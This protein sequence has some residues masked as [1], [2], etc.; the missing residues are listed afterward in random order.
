MGVTAPTV[1][2]MV[3]SLEAIGLVRTKR[4]PH[5]R[6]QRVVELTKE[7]LA[8]IRAAIDSFIGGRI[9]Q[10]ILDRAFG[11]HG[12]R[13]MSRAAVIFQRMCDYEYLLD[14][15]RETCGDSA[16]LHYPWHPDD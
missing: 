2:R 16:K 15:M 8:R 4:D 1:S 5:D 6:R 12:M 7:G 9:G 11:R 3:K 13:R 14:C 10:K